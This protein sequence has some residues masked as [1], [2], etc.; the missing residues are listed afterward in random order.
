MCCTCH[1]TVLSLNRS[2][3][4][5]LPSPSRER[6]SLV[7]VSVSGFECGIALRFSIISRT[8][9]FGLRY[10]PARRISGVDITRSTPLGSSPHPC[11]QL[12]TPRCSRAS[13]LYRPAPSRTPFLTP[14]FRVDVCALFCPSIHEDTI[15][16]D[17]VVHTVCS[18]SIVRPR[19]PRSSTESFRDSPL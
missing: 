5:S 1:G 15:R 12:L 16:L 3:M 6:K 10:R 11:N 4:T 7:H 14:W 17:R 8:Q 2:P 9:L 19:S 13:N 18:G